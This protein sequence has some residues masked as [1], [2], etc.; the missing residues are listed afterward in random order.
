MKI[1]NKMYPKHP[2]KIAHLKWDF[3]QLIDKKDV[4]I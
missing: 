2:I 3:I 4:F 1:Q